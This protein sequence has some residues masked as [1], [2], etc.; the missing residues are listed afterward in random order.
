M[1]KFDKFNKQKSTF[2]HK[3]L[4][5]FAGFDKDEIVDNYVIFYLREL[6]K[7]ADIIAVFDNDLSDFEKSKIAPF[8]IKIIAQN[9][10]EYDFGSYK[11][12]YFFAQEILANYDRLVLCNDSVFGPFYS[13]EKIFAKIPHDENVVWGVAKH[14]RKACNGWAGRDFIEEHLQSYFIAL[15]KKAFL[16]PNFQ[17]FMKDIKR[18]ENK[19]EVI[20]QYEIGMSQMLKAQG[21]EL[22]SSYENMC[23][24]ANFAHFRVLREFD[25]AFIKKSFLPQY[26]LKNAYQI[27]SFIESRGGGFDVCLILN[28]Y[29]RMGGIYLANKSQIDEIQKFKRLCKKVAKFAKL[30]P[31]KSL[32]E[33]FF[34]RYISEEFY[35]KS[36]RD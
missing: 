8:C 35:P 22:K 34:K 20:F 7:N 9:H 4:A 27:L 33:G 6:A 32:R 18:L 2:K 28:Y 19:D 10:G 13:F 11:R 21:F 14:L 23:D 26:N 3:N 31:I 36:M 16:N 29:E 1:Q 17:H 12:G 30:I 24:L 25:G 15:P 5:I